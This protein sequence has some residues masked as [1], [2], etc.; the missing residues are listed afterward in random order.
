MVFG[1]IVSDNPKGHLKQSEMHFEDKKQ[2]MPLDIDEIHRNRISCDSS[3]AEKKRRKSL[4]Y[5]RH[6]S[7][8]ITSEFFY[9]CMLHQLKKIYQL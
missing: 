2:Y 6:G 4:V 3:F 7:E 5:E 8:K 1:Q 9:C